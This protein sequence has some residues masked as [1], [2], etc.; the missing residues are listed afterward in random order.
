VELSVT[1]ALAVKLHKE[2]F[3]MN[4]FKVSPK[5][6]DDEASNIY[7]IK[8]LPLIKKASF[9]INGKENFNLPLIC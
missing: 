9:S 3:R 7:L 1:D 5:D 2:I 8:S 4:G 6:L